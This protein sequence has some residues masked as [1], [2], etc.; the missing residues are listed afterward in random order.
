MNKL[1]KVFLDPFSPEQLAIFL[2]MAMQMDKY[3]LTAQDVMAVC[4]D[5]I[6]QD[7]SG[8]EYKYSPVVPPDHSKTMLP[9]PLKLINCPICA[10]AVRISRVNISKCTNVGG[11]WKTSVECTNPDCRFMELS[12]ETINEWRIKQCR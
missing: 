6:T 2:T 5:R 4:K 7:L 1:A 3:G 11:D 9:T 12:K 8:K 10:S